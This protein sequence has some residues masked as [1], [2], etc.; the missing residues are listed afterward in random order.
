MPKT[1]KHPTPPEGDKKLAAASEKIREIQDTEA[2]ITQNLVKKIKLPNEVIRQKEPLTKG[3]DQFK[4]TSSRPGFWGKI[5]S[6]LGQGLSS[7][8]ESFKNMFSPK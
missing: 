6:Q 4:K 8:V 1:P 5:W 3:A 7:F 2:Q